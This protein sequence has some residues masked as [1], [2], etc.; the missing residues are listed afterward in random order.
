LE[1]RVEQVLLGSEGIGG[2]RKRV[3]GGRAV[4]ERNDPMYAHMNKKKDVCFLVPSL[5]GEELRDRQNGLKLFS[6]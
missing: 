6:R 2:K 4:R 5:R 1:K 3:W